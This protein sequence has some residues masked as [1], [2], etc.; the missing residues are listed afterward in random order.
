VGG[1]GGA[2]FN[3]TNH[4]VDVKGRGGGA[5]A[6][7]VCMCASALFSRKP[8]CDGGW[9]GGLLGWRAVRGEPVVIG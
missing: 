2:G 3:A 7:I 6:F 4:A 1:E 8:L 5:I 9:M